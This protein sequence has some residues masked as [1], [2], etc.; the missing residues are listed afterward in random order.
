LLDNGIKNREVKLLPS[1]KILQEKQAAVAE[2]VN[3]LNGTISGVLVSYQ[4]ITVADDTK[5]RAEL[6]KAGVKYKVLK[7][8]L[9][10]F[11]VKE[12]GLEGL[13]EVLEGTTA[14]AVNTEG[15]TAAAKILCEYAKKNEKFVIKAG[16]VEGNVID[17]DNVKALAK[18]PSKEVLIAQVLAG[19]NAPITGL[20]NVLNG[21]IRG[22]AVALNAIAEK[23]AAEAA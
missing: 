12:A 4:G 19:F 3:T 21:N 14:L 9:L 5:L 22:L 2:I 10:N 17:A 8:S 18:L 7:N 15:E 1:N 16:F 13:T 11:A 23:K 6:R 20:V